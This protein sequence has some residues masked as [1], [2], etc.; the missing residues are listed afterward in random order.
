MRL[1]Q[2]HTLVSL[3]T[4]MWARREIAQF[5]EVVPN[6]RISV[7]KTQVTPCS[8]LVARCSLLVARCSLLVASRPY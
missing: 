5:G 6:T 4:A 2:Q 7:L 3:A 1:S 8:M